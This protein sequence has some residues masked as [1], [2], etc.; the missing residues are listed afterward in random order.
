MTGTNPTPLEL[1]K[2]DHLLTD[3]ERDIAGAVRE[4]V[5]QRVRPYVTDWYERGEVDLS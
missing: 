3:D 5:D 1:L 2:I 4:F